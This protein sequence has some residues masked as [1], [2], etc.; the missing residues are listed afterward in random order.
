MK[1]QK[2]TLQILVKED[3]NYCEKCCKTRNVIERMVQEV[4]GLK[5]KVEISFEN[6]ASNNIIEKYGVLTPP[7]IIINNSVYLEGHVPVIKRL[8]KTLL[9]LLNS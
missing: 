1:I 9:D 5:D 7:V 3:E 4:P 8:S 6:I 2:L